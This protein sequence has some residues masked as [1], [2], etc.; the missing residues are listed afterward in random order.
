MENL[1]E[2]RVGEEGT[3]VE[4][5]ATNLSNPFTSLLR[6]GVKDIQRIPRYK[7]FKLGEEVV[8]KT[9]NGLKYGLIQYIV[10]IIT[11]GPLDGETVFLLNSYNKI[12]SG[13]LAYFF[14]LKK[15]FKI[16]DYPLERNSI[17][18]SGSVGNY[19]A[20]DGISIHDVDKYLILK[21]TIQKESDGKFEYDIYVPD[22]A[23][24]D[25]SNIPR[26]KNVSGMSEL[27]DD[28]VSL[29]KQRGVQIHFAGHIIP[30]DGY[31]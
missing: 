16:E 5:I 22:F 29:L 25:A 18:L 2:I 6:Y 1:R 30:N 7:N 28:E 3:Y 26:T 20:F 4:G 12:W 19:G 31:F 14:D 23:P 10:N 24:I 15:I 9:K 27:D 8:V 11:F 13:C 21:Q 17:L